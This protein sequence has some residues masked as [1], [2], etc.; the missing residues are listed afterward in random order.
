ML[1]VYQQVSSMYRLFGF[2][3]LWKLHYQYSCNIVLALIFAIFKSC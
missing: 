1:I 2:S 3:K